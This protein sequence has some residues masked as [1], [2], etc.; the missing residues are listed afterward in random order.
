M[1]DHKEGEISRHMDEI[2]QLKDSVD[3]HIW[4]WKNLKFRTCPFVNAVK[5][6]RIWRWVW[7]HEA[8]LNQLIKSGLLLHLLW[9]FRRNCYPWWKFCKIFRLVCQRLK[10]LKRFMSIKFR[11]ILARKCLF[12][13]NLLVFLQDLVPFQHL[14]FPSDDGGDG[15]DN[16]DEELV[17]DRM[18]QSFT[19]H[20][21]LVERDIVDAR[22]LWYATLGP[23]PSSA[24]DFRAWKTSCCWSLQSWI[25]ISDR[26]YL[27]HWLSKAYEVNSDEVIKHDSGCVPR[28]DRWLAAE[29][30]K[31]LMCLSCSSRSWGT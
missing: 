8:P 2:H 4:F 13:F 23:V 10:M 31:G 17:R 28:L 5:I 22:S 14:R 9:P 16:E 11:A 24:S 1:L 20:R 21:D 26:D 19:S 15:F 7:L 27:E 25:I 3:S 29:I 18:P 6:W 12:R 30:S